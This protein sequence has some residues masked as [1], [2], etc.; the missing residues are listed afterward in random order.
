VQLLRRFA[1][2]EPRVVSRRPPPPPGVE[3]W[4]DAN[5]LN[6][7]FQQGFDAPHREMR[8]PV[9]VP[10]PRQWR[11][12]SVT[13]PAAGIEVRV[14]GDSVTRTEFLMDSA[15]VRFFNRTN[16]TEYNLRT[17]DSIF[18]MLNSRFQMHPGAFEF[19][20]VFR[21]LEEAQRRVFEQQRKIH[22]Q[23][24]EKEIRQ[25]SNDKSRDDE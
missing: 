8:P 25:R 7:Q 24:R 17:V 1:D 5:A 21:S 12:Y 2:Q 15:M 9:V 19:D 14:S 10:M 22:Q 3:V 6:I 23:L 20:S 4:G 18:S 11:M 13:S 16:P